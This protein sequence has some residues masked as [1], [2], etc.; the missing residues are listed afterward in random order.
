MT[1]A[2]GGFFS[3]EDADSAIDPSDPK[4]KGEGAF[5]VWSYDEIAG[6]L[7][8]P[9]TAMFCDH[10]GVEDKG[11]VDHDPHGEF[12]GKSILFVKR[13]ADRTLEAART[14]L[15]GVR[16]QR[17]RPDRDEKILTSWNS[18]MISAFAK[19][20]QVLDEERYR[21]VAVRAAGFIEQR[22]YNRAD[23]TLLRRY[24]DG[25]AAIPGFLD[26][27][28]FFV[29]AMLDLYETDFDP[30]RIE[31]AIA[32]TRKMQDLFEDRENG[33]FFTTAEGDASLV[34]RMKD[35]YDG[36]EPAANSVALLN[37]LRLAEITNHEEFQKA[38]ERT[39]SA[40][41]PRIANQPVAGSQK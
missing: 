39:L 10:Y 4:T 26:D 8:E 19:G 31:M 27:Y 14:K 25:D 2:Q 20:A 9:A 1:H 18:L 29:Q 33:A 36:A 34:L 37:L 13:P 38:A 32:L 23:G 16:N 6:I 28:A 35:D 5:Y 11:N 15:L 41:S 12:T 21:A 7:G 40:L 22:M 17:P 3:A 24:R 30:R